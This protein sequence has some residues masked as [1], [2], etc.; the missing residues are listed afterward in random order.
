MEFFTRQFEMEEETPILGINPLTLAI[1]LIV[2]TILIAAGLSFWASG[3]GKKSAEKTAD[4]SLA[5]FRLY[6]GSYDSTT[7]SLSLVLENLHSKE[8]TDMT[9]YL[10]YSDDEIIEKPFERSLKGTK[11]ETYNFNE[12]P[13]DF[14]RGVIKTNCP[15][16]SVKFTEQDGTLVQV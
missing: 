7:S 9:L 12:I 6:S 15:E 11:L 4:C 13:K 3:I 14:E 1:I 2:V 10:F 8:L 16:V 5:E